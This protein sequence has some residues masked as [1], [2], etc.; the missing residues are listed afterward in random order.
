MKKIFAL[1]LS[2]L[3]VV[4][5][6]QPI[7]KQEINPNVQTLKIDTKTF[8]SDYQDSVDSLL[9]SFKLNN[10]SPLNARIFDIADK[11]VYS[12]LESSARWKTHGE[13]MANMYYPNFFV[14]NK[15]TAFCFILYDSNS[16]LLEGYSRVL[17]YNEILDYLTF[18]EMGHCL[19]DYINQTTG[20]KFS[21]NREDTE[22]FADIFAMANLLYLKKEEQAEKV[23]KINEAADKKDYHYQPQRLRK[24]LEMLRGKNINEFVGKPN[25]NKIV[26]ISKDTF[27]SLKQN[28]LIN[29]IF[30]SNKD[31]KVQNAPPMNNGG[32]MSGFTIIRK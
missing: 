31:F 29:P 6:A 11:Q 2:F 15:P 23:V 19:E 7:Y 24:A 3:S 12:F 9:G 32:N 26:D 14:N 21:D 27:Y 5:I 16:P 4:V 8:I 1:I 10:E 28:E 18:H 20:K 25:V 22:L 17:N 30:A 13:M